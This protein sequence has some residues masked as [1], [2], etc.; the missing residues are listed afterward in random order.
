MFAT[1]H[2]GHQGWLIETATSRILV[3][4]L[5]GDGFD[6]KSNP[7]VSVYPPRRIDFAAFPPI[8]AVVITHEHP[9]HLNIASLLCLDR[10]VPCLLSGRASLAAEG[11]LEELGFRTTRLRSGEVVSVGDIELHPFHSV[12]IT[13]EEWDVVPLLIR[14]RGGHGSLATSIDAPE[15]PDFARFVMERGGAP[16]IWVSTRIHHDMFPI[17]RG[18]TQSNGEKVTERLVETF[19]SVV[20][21]NFRRGTAPSVLALLEDGFAFGG[22]LGWLNPHVFPG[23]LDRVAKIIA[24]KFPD[25]AVRTP[26][27]GHRY[28]FES[29]RLV[30]EEESRP[31]LTVAERSTWPE[32][33]AKPLTGAIPDYVPATGRREFSADDLDALL[34]ELRNFAGYLYGRELHRGLY[35]RSQ[36]GEGPVGFVLRTSSEPIVLRYR[37]ES[38][39]FEQTPVDNLVAGLECWASDLLAALRFDFLAGNILVGRYRKWSQAGSSLFCH[40]DLELAVYTHPLRHPERTLELYRNIL[41]GLGPLPDPI[42]RYAGR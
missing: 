1:T 6:H 13:R 3:D 16:G 4:P 7:T 25:I 21:R 35:T 34:A 27:P 22:D 11:L 39:S 14:D 28:V 38:C 31:F 33:D 37:P 5:L 15:T 23:R 29:E 26:Q 18:A 8:D 36:S 20:E 24:E 17:Q 12:E 40:L 19:T 2:L 42:I 30:G 32:R 9:D 41:R 10:D